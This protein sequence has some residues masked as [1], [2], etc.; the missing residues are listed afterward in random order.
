MVY[1][2]RSDFVKENEE[3]E[4]N[5]ANSTPNASMINDR[6]AC[7]PT[8]ELYLFDLSVATPFDSCPLWID[9]V[10]DNVWIYENFLSNKWKNKKKCLQE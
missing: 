9:S 5:T 2:F 7:E 8:I 10:C 1:N 3:R 4:E 6:F